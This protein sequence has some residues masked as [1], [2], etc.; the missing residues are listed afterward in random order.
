MENKCA[1][2]KFADG[3]IQKLSNRK[4]ILFYSI[5]PSPMT[6]H[7]ILTSSC[8]GLKLVLWYSWRAELSTL[9]Q[10]PC[11][12]QSRDSM[13]CH[14]WLK[15]IKVCCHQDS[16]CVSPACKRDML[17]TSPQQLTFHHPVLRN[18]TWHLLLAPLPTSHLTLHN[19]T[20]IHPNGRN[21]MQYKIH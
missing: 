11:W 2:I 15:H 5:S 10:S 18:S 17:T 20:H 12:L 6:V 16:N 9:N 8:T 4:I 14:T 21:L 13:Y 3:S 1:S 19:K 7:P